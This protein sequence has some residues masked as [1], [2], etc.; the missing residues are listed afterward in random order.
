MD[1]F[2]PKNEAHQI[3][4]A[5]KRHMSFQREQDSLKVTAPEEQ[6]E[7]L[8]QEGKSDLIKWQQDLDDELMELV[9][10]LQGKAKVDGHFKKVGNDKSLCNDKFVTNIVIPQCKPFLSRNLINSNFTED[11]ILMDLKNTSNDIAAN[12]ADGYDTYGI[13]FQNYDVILRLIKNVIKAGAF[14]A[15]NGWTKKTDSTTFKKLESS[16]DSTNAHDGIFG[17]LKK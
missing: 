3:V 17:S 11:R 13:E 4:E 8:N 14:R 2:T 6:T 15:L 9:Y 10:R 12:M 5:E 16:Y 1:M 7:I